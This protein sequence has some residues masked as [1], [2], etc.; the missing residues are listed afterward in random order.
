MFIIMTSIFE[1]SW[2]VSLG[3]VGEKP[4]PKAGIWLSTTIMPIS[5]M[6]AVVIIPMDML[7]LPRVGENLKMNG[8]AVVVGDSIRTDVTDQIETAIMIT[9]VP[10]VLVGTMGSTTVGKD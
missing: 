5:C 4:T 1:S 6:V 7:H 8:R 10:T 9:D 3:E 2:L